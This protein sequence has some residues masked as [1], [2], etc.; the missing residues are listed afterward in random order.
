[1]QTF[2][3]HERDFVVE[4]L[5]DT[6]HGLTMNNVASRQEGDGFIRMQDALEVLDNLQMLYNKSKDDGDWT[7]G[8]TD[9]TWTFTLEDAQDAL[10]SYDTE[11][12]ECI[13]EQFE[14]ACKDALKLAQKRHASVDLGNADYATL[15]HRIT[16]Y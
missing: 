1:M 15:A 11:Y 3:Q 4:F 2:T 14:D 13:C 7:K 10:T 6:L 16:G 8:E 9:A 5:A 12:R